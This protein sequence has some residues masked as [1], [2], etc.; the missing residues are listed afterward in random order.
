MMQKKHWGYK[1]ILLVVITILLISMVGCNSASNKA[2]EGAVENDQKPAA[3]SPSQTTG[4]G[5][6]DKSAALSFKPGK[7]TAK[8]NG[9]NGPIEVETEFTDTAIKNVK[10][11]SQSETEGIA[12]GPLKIVPEKIVSEQ[13]LAIDAVSGASM[14]TKGILEAVEDCAKQAGGDLTVLKQAKATAENKEVEEITV[15]VA[16]VG[17]GAAGTAAA[18]AA[19][20]SG[21]RVVLLE[22]TATPMGAGTMAG[23]M[24]AADSQQQKDKKATVSKQWLYDQY[25]AASDGYMNSL[26]VRNIIDEAGTTVDWLNANG[27][28]M[29]L[30]DAG[31]GFAF[32]HIGMPATLHGY[33]EGGT[34]AIT[35][36]IKSFEAKSGQ[37]RFST[38]V[39]ELLTDSNGAVT[40]VMAKKE[41]G[42][43][44]KVNAK[45]VVI[46]TGGF[47]G[48]NEMMEKYF[49]KKFT[50][51][52]I[53]TNTGDGIQMAWKAGAD[54]YGM[55]STQYFAQIFTPEEIAKMAPINK[56]WYSLTKFSEYPNLRVNTLGQR[57]SDETKV[58]LFAVHGAEIHMQPKETEFLILDSAMLNT[59]KKKGLAAIE[60][61]FSKWKGKRQFYMEFNEPN[62]TDTILAAE[63]TPTDYTPLLDSMKGTGVV[64]RAGTL[65]ALAQEIGVDKDTFLASAKQYNT[66]IAQ[67][68]DPM[69]FSDTK[70]LVPLKQGPYYAIKYVG[71]NLG[72]LGGV[73][74][75]EKIEATDSDG[76]AIPGLYVAGADAGGMYGQAYVDFEGGTLG[77][78]YTSGR[79]AGIHAAGYSHK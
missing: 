5:T 40:G 51:G 27:A 24:F 71:R 70:R 73:R 37:V 26:L 45:A 52:Q 42:S 53:A 67:G 44:L 55:T 38:P 75:N 60:P 49:G 22:K 54:P 21:A 6:S 36:L 66:A 25:M 68:N 12:Q 23:G 78:A 62:D 58:T 19:E 4:A 10:V 31:T 28:K 17:A 61:H 43:H 77:F 41:D 16:V 20:D 50:P 13:T 7:Y 72:T 59:I 18:L 29:T 9:K 79:L 35:K 34:V 47:G 56:D 69:F 1:G 39:T 46:A 64:H 48:N 65:E 33:Q 11:L 3:A 63:N 30:V 76:R 14:T 8:G 15:D 74:I 32:E 2:D 57:F